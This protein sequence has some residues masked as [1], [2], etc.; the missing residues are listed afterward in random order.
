MNNPFPEMIED[1]SSGIGVTSRDHDGLLVYIQGHHYY[2]EPL[3]KQMTR[4]N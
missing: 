3:T 1:E 2:Y 4:I